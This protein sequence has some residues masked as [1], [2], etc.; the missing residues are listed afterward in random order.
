[1]CPQSVI[2]KLSENVRRLVTLVEELSYYQVT[3]VFAHT[4]NQ[5]P[6]EQIS[7]PKGQWLTQVE[8]GLA[9]ALCAK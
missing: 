5:L 4:L 2:L 9:W 3:N 1:V 6:P 7:V 8:L